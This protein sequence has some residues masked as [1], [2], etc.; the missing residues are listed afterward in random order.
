MIFGSQL[1][2][3]WFTKN[4]ANAIKSTS[5][6][7]GLRVNSATPVRAVPSVP[8]VPVRPP[9][10]PGVVVSIRAVSTS[11]STQMTPVRAARTNGTLRQLP[12][13]AGRITLLAAARAMICPATGP[14]R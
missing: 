10:R 12:P 14:V 4:T 6:M 9:A 2:S 5:R 8:A 13:V 11:H 3:P 1:F 7:T